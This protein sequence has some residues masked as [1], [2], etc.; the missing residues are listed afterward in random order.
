[1]HINGIS[2]YGSRLLKK[3]DSNYGLLEILEKIICSSLIHF[4]VRSEG[5]EV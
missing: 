3:T 2:S 5:L 4:V 1:M